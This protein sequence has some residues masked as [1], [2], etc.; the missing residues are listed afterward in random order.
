[1]PL[2]VLGHAQPEAA[3]LVGAMLLKDP[4]VRPS[5]AAVLAHPMWWTP[6]QQLA[7]LVDTSDR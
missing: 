3:N 7:F 5:M 6:E 2:T 4:G 1:M